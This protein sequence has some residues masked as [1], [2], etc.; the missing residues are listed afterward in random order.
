[1]RDSFT[2]FD[3]D[4]SPVQRRG[5][6]VRN[7]FVFNRCVHNRTTDGVG[8]DLKQMNDSGKLIRLEMIDQLVS[9]LLLLCGISR[10]H[11]RL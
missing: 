3:G 5:C 8:H 2:A 10:H 4:V 6:L 9:L 1:M 7:V 11:F